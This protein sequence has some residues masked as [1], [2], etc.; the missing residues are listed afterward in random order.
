MTV[1]KLD[2]LLDE[3]H[4]EAVAKKPQQLAARENFVSRERVNHW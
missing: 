1:A 2:Q 3:E 4:V